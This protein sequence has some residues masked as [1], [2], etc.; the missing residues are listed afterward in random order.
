MVAMEMKENTFVGFFCPVCYISV[1][2]VIFIVHQPK[3]IKCF[4]VIRD[5]S[6]DHFL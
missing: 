6:L 2:M 3:L 4:D 5:F 1:A